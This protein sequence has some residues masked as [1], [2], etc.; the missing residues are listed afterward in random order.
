MKSSSEGRKRRPP[1]GCG[2]SPNRA[3]SAE[4]QLRKGV[5][6]LCVLALLQDQ[7]LY[8]FELAKSLSK[9]D[10]LVTS[11]GT[12]YPLL[13]RLRRDGYVATSWRESSEGPPR[14]Y[15]ALTPDG[16]L[17]LARFREDWRRFCSAVDAVM[18]QGET[19]P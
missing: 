17:A 18:D 11:E 3:G 1:T 12:M 14:K 7:E 4:A 9:F 5:I 10:G 2:I 6:E 13:A 15:Y 19:R 16:S 8:G